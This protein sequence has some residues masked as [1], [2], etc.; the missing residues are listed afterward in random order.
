MRCHLALAIAAASACPSFARGEVSAYAVAPTTPEVHGPQLPQ[1]ADESRE[2]VRLASAI[3]TTANSDQQTLLRTKLAEL[4]R[5]QSEV[6]ELRHST[7]TPSQ[8]LV[9]VEMLEVSL[10]KLRQMGIDLPQMIPGVV[11][12]PHAV[13]RLRPAANSHPSQPKIA[14]LAADGTSTELI[15]LL[16]Q[17]NIGKVLADPSLV[18]TSGRPASF[19]VGGQI[20]MPAAPGANSTIEYRNFGTQIEL[21]AASIG[22]GRVRIEINPS[23]T[24]IDDSRTIEIQGLRIPAFRVR[25]C[26]TAYEANFEE[27]VIL[28]GGSTMRVESLRH[29]DGHIEER[30]NEI[31]TWYV[32]RAEHIEPMDPSRR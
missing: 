22:N 11:V 32:V 28:G 7:N 6:D 10:T 18:T 26:N 1:V 14:P 12:S 20:P 24:E 23:I 30:Q 4:D 17:Q 8:I 13:E 29:A 9:R 31:A 16:K 27:T 2:V 3:E 15:G 19:L 5:L 25:Q 21:R